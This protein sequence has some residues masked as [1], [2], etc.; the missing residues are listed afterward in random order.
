MS[1]L[2]VL[3]CAME[4]HNLENLAPWVLEKDRDLE[5]QDA[6]HAFVLDKTADKTADRVRELLGDSYKGRLGIHGPFYGFS[7]D[8]VDPAIRKV[9]GCASTGA[10]DGTSHGRDPDGAAP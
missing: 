2:P 10:E 1:D 8:S 5:I 4:L 9:C 3:G 6:Y 7:L